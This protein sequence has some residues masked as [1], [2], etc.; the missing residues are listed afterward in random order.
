MRISFV[1]GGNMASALIGG[2]L[3]KSA[4]AADIRVIEPDAG[5]RA[6]LIERFGVACFERAQPAALAGEAVVLAVKPQQMREVARGLA[7]LLAGQ[8]VISVAAGI[9][10][11]DLSRWLGGHARIVRTI[12]NTPALIGEGITALAAAPA[13]SGADRDAAGAILAAV[14]QTLWVDDESLIDAVTAV[15][16]SGP[17]YVFFFMEAI[18]EAARAMGLDAAQARRLTLATFGG[19]ARLA[20]AS[21]DPPSVLRERVTS[22]GGTTA[23]ALAVMDQQGVRAHIAQALAA[24]CR[25]S[26]ELGEEFGRD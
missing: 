25:R 13:V 1:G 15:S 12:P 11:A 21:G 22:S 23:A 19:A 18:E 4:S 8:L 2:L 24:A 10:L 16:G 9:R 6:R 3:A 7:P 20:A 17:A 26:G 5:A 14:G